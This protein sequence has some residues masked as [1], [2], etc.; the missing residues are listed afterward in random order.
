MNKEIK[1]L[2]CTLRD[3][4]YYNNWTFEKKVVE[5]MIASLQ[6]CNIDYIEIGYRSL[7]GENFKTSK[8]DFLKQLKI[9]KK[10]NFACMIDV[11]EYVSN[12]KLNKQELEKSFPLRE[13]NLIDTCR[14]ATTNEN[15]SYALESIDF[16]REK[17][18]IVIVNMMGVNLLDEMQIRKACR[19]IAAHDVTA[20][21]FADSFGNL[22][23]EQ[24]EK[25]AK[26]FIDNSKASIGF[27]AHDNQSLAFSN[28]IQAIKSG[29]TFIDSTFLGMGRGAGNLKTEQISLYLQNLGYHYESS[30]LMKSLDD[31]E[32]LKK[33]YEWG[34]NHLY[35]IAATK[36]I[37]P[38]YVQILQEKKQLSNEE[39]ESILLKIAKKQ[40]AEKTKFSKGI[41]ED[42]INNKQLKTS[43]MIPARMKSSRFHGKPLEKILGIP[44]IIRVAKI[45]EAAVG[46]EN[47]YVATDS[48]QIAKIAKQNDFKYIMTKEARTG[49]DRI[50]EAVREI[51]SDI[52]INLQGDEPLVDPN[53]I[54]RV[55]KYKENNLKSVVNCYSNLFSTEKDN[56][57]IPKVAIDAEQNL[58]Y[59]SRSALPGTKDG[60][61]KE[62]IKYYKQVCIYAFTKDELDFY[63]SC[64]PGNLEQS[65]DI[66]ILRF[67]E[68]GKGVKMLYLDSDTIAVDYPEDIEKVETYLSKKEKQ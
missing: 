20:L 40:L 32:K 57:S 42:Y 28:T 47:V 53:D 3:G 62:N 46:K 34:P 23:P 33:Q 68:N 15:L 5:K 52:I 49:T 59:M 21:Y 24:V 29:V 27:H 10:A 14:I 19:A 2:D 8:E 18:Y 17:G 41:I 51:D 66:E 58:L 31:F 26:I 67:L 48:E 38:M 61:E 11:K 56:N 9:D 35:S 1:L 44:M 30:K 65:E 45:A 25:M 43:I 54:K 39:K 22:H 16:M 60:T 4:G 37:H 6:E 13:N 50:C 55:I 63:G 36:N 64:N 7:H 12:K